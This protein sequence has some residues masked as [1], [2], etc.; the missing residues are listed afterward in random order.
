MLYINIYYYIHYSAKNTIFLIARFL[1]NNIYYYSKNVSQNFFKK[2]QKILKF[3]VDKWKHIVYIIQC[4]EDA[5]P[6]DAQKNT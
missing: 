2:N 1:N 5:K 4:R 6:Q 3:G